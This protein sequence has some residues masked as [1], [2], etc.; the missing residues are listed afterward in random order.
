MVVRSSGSSQMRIESSYQ[1]R[2][3]D[4]QKDNLDEETLDWKVEE[5]DAEYHQWPWVQLQ[6]QRL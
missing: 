2:H 4:Q 1:I 5:R 6:Q 3:L